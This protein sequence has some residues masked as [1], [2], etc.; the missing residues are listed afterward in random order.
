VKSQGSTNRVFGT[1]DTTRRSAVKLGFTGLGH[2]GRL[3]AHNLA[4]SEAALTAHARDEGRLNEYRSKGICGTTDVAE[5]ADSD[6]L[7]LCLLGTVTVRDVLLG[8]GGLAG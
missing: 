4:K 8:E 7:F 1:A 5:L 3:N 6:I 2:M